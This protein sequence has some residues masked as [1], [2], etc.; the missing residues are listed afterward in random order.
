[1]FNMWCAWAGRPLQCTH[2]SQGPGPDGPGRIILP[3][4]TR[5]PRCPPAAMD[6]N[7]TRRGGPDQPGPCRADGCPTHAGFGVGGRARVMAASD[8]DHPVLAPA[9]RC[10][11][12]DTIMFRRRCRQSQ[13]VTG[14]GTARR[15]PRPGYVAGAP[16]DVT[17]HWACVLC[18]PEKVPLSMHA[19]LPEHAC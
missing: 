18:C 16:S 12:C 3:A 4:P 9:R 11:R 1:M 6:P 13:S 8:P 5:T 7:G 15:R 10:R 17:G 2:G 14:L 19:L